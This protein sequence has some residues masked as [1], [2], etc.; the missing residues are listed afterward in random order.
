V[1]KTAPEVLEKSWLL[2]QNFALNYSMGRAKAPTVCFSVVI[3]R[4]VTPYQPQQ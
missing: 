4:S 3:R 1:L 2:A